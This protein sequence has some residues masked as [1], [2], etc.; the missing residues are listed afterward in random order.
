[1]ASSAV[2]ATD[3]SL[4]KHFLHTRGLNGPEVLA[5]TEEVLKARNHGRL[6]VA[7]TRARGARSLGAVSQSDTIPVGNHNEQLALFE[8]L[9]RDQAPSGD[10]PPRTPSGA[11][12]CRN[13]RDAA[14]QAAAAAARD[15]GHH[16]ER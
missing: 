10:P 9:G 13:W 2:Q 15:G 8:R 7:I 3:S 16:R 12:R 1:M 5:R 4:F 6:R 11:I 14:G